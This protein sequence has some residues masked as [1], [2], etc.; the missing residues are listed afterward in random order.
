[1]PTA[2]IV[3]GSV[4]G[5]ASALALSGTGYRVLVLERAPGPPQWSTADPGSGWRRPTAPQGLQSHTLTSLGVRVLRERAPRLLADAGAAGATVLDLTRALPADA[6]DSAPEPG[7]GDLVALG[8]RRSTLELLLHR[9]VSDTPDV[10]VRHDTTVT[11]LELHP[12]HRG[13][14]AVVTGAGERVRAD[15]VVDA[16]GR[17]ALSR[18]W[19][20]DAGIPV[21]ADRTSA[22]GLVGHTRFYRLRGRALPG[23]LNRGHGVGDVYDHYAGVLHP[24]DDGT[25]SIALGSLPGD[26]VLQAGL[27][28][29]TGFTAAAR[30]TPGL[31]P[32]LEDGVSSPISPVRVISSPPNT[33][34]GAAGPRQVPVPGLFQVGDAACI[35]NP[36]FGRGM[37]LALDHAFRLADLLAEQPDVDAAQR[38]AVARMTHELFLPWYE[39]AAGA[40]RLRSARWQAAVDG[41]P[42]VPVPPTGG[43]PSGAEIAAAART[44]GT[45]WRGLTRM[46]MTLRTPAQLFADDKFLAR[47][48]QAA[49]AGPAPTPPPGRD[50]LLRR[51]TATEGTR[52]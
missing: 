9:T 52:A 49:P 33:L 32:W 26:R 5:L 38:L 48:R 46:L 31:A 25:F 12:G 21:T 22:S 44:D 7:D 40:D 24:G 17:R 11:G 8:C 2:V 6:A 35:T 29:R 43:L 23:P 20:H 28:T 36:L 39:Q 13:V 3:G 16:T 15:I 1:M 19:L 34:R 51:V 50:E 10:T 41:R 42:A 45:V 47:V 30:A 37:S 27:R 14:A 4:A 18:R